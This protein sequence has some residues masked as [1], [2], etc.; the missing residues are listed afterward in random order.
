MI[1]CWLLAIAA[2]CGETVGV[3][4]VNMDKRFERID[5]TALN[6]N[7]PSER[8]LLYLRRHD[9][10]TKWRND[11]E[12]ILTELDAQV[13]QNPDREALFALMEL[14]YIAARRAANRPE[15]AAMYS[16]SCAVYAYSFIFDP[17]LGPPLEPYH[18]HTRAAC[19]FYNRSFAAFAIHLRDR[20]IKFT[21][22]R[23]F[24]VIGGE[25]TIVDRKSELR[26][27]PSEFDTFFVT[28]EFEV[29][30]LE[31]VYQTF[32]LGVPVIL[33]RTPG[34]SAAGDPEQRFMP[35]L[36]QTYAATALLKIAPFVSKAEPSRQKFEAELMIFDPTD[37]DRLS[38]GDRTAALETDITTP[39]AY[40]TGRSKLPGGISGV[41]D[42]GSW[43]N[44]QGLYM[45]QPYEKDKIPVV[46]VHGLMSSPRTWLA[47]FNDLSGDPV[48]RKHY[49]FWF[50]MYPTGNPIMY[51]AAIL[52]DSLNEVQQTFDPERDDLAFNRMV[53]VGHSMGGVISRLMIVDSGDSFWRMV[54]DT[55]FEEADLAPEQREL[56]RRVFFFD[57]LPY[58]SR[59]IFIAAPHRGSEWADY[60]IGRLGSALVGLPVAMLKTT[61]GF[62]QAVVTKPFMQ[63]DVSEAEHNIGQVPTGIDGLSPGNK[64]YQVLDE[65]EVPPDLPHHT[66]A[67]NTEAPD[68]PGGSDGIVPYRSSYLEGAESEKIVHS[69]H[70][71][72]NH[73][74]AILEVHRILLLHLERLG[75]L[76]DSAE[77]GS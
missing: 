1:G 5:R 60:R 33:I 13:R 31:N 41:L 20:K 52:R 61:A 59:A 75:L 74:L 37:S 71:A 51:S 72:H 58:V 12:G 19:E 6:E 24:K 42:V 30:G 36:N 65:I 28:Y 10:E 26:W 45:L 77:E 49:Q 50:F 44:V 16:L 17:G 62:L 22:Q 25:L 68:T 34:A 35:K 21:S 14:S 66:I 73:P 63:Q 27:D 70:S 7:T 46:F 15:T 38:V 23:R 56:A 64:L 2:G 3:R 11:P 4:R 69:G 76:D 48:L 40:L 32:G 18:P 39:L 9:V 29:E 43:Q 54:T 53:L 55:P 47:M 57:H 8:T 67:G